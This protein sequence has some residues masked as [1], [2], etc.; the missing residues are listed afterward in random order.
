MHA[1]F[2]RSAFETI[3][4]H[5]GKAWVHTTYCKR[6]LSSVDALQVRIKLHQSMLCF[7][8]NAVVHFRENTSHDTHTHT[9]ISVD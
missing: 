3:G 5:G 6:A 7:A 8:K 2:T 4:A 9:G 1:Y